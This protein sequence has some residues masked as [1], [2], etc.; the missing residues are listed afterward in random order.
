MMQNIFHET[1]NGYAS[2]PSHLDD[3]V[4]DEEIGMWTVAEHEDPEVKMAREAEEMQIQH[5]AAKVAQAVADDIAALRFEHDQKEAADKSW[6]EQSDALL[7]GI[8]SMLPTAGR[9]FG[10]RLGRVDSALEDAHRALQKRK[11]EWHEAGVD[12]LSAPWGLLLDTSLPLSV[13]WHPADIIRLRS[14][15]YSLRG[16]KSTHEVCLEILKRLGVHL[17]PHMH[18]T[19]R[20]FQLACRV[21]SERKFVHLLP[22]IAAKSVGLRRDDADAKDLVHVAGSH[23]LN[24]LLLS[25]AHHEAGGG[26]SSG[27]GA[28]SSSN[29]TAP[30]PQRLST[31]GRSV[32]GLPWAPGD[33]DIF[34][35]CRGGA[36]T[37]QSVELFKAVVEHAVKACHPLYQGARTKKFDSVLALTP[38]LSG[39]LVSDKVDPKVKYTSDTYHGLGGHP[40]AVTDALTGSRG[41]AYE[42][43]A[44]LATVAG[45]IPPQLARIISKLN[46][47]LGIQRPIRVERVAEVYPFRY[48][49]RP[50]ITTTCQFSTVYPM[51]L[52]INVIQYS[53]SSLSSSS[54]A[55]PAL[56]LCNAFDLVPARVAMRVGRDLMPSYMMSQETRQCIERRELKLT[57][58]AFG[59]AK[60]SSLYWI[61]EAIEKQLQRITKYQKYGFKLEGNADVVP[62]EQQQPPDEAQNT[63]WGVPVNVGWATIG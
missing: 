29:A 1:M 50:A 17:R 7:N 2:S 23:A 26:G 45:E 10:S 52:K 62:L 59:P 46:P 9:N 13:D 22:T 61:H 63:E 58:Y 56:S 54:G 55:M 44:M 35:A 30:P 57:K 14:C 34:V 3:S 6:V 42:R 37:K 16:T 19:R 51:P 48:A 25:Q 18:E 21:F 28:G 8:A 20:V 47:L 32:G 36:R 12:M 41:V 5:T 40:A 11:V 43:D 60:E 27:A 31:H 33:I 24:R 39:S 4:F 53:A 15:C 38:F 49:P